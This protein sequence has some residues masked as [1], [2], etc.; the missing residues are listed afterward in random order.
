MRSAAGSRYFRFFAPDVTAAM[1]IGCKS[2]ELTL[3]EEDM[4]FESRPTADLVQLA[5]AGGGFRLNAAVR[6]TTE[7]VQIAAAASRGGG[8]ITFCGLT[9]RLTSDLV[10]IASAGKGT[11]AFDE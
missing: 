8:R 2:A 1:C 7:L 10:Q 4:S 9:G 6:Q 3:L 11:V 5:A